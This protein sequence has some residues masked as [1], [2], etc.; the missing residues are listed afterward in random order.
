VANVD[1]LMRKLA[2]AALEKTAFTPTETD[3][4]AAAAGPPGAALSAPEG[5]GLVS[6]LGSGLGLGAGYLLGKRFQPA[7]AQ[8][9]GS[10]FGGILSRYPQYVGMA[11]GSLLGARMARKALES[12][13]VDDISRQYAQ[14]RYGA[15]G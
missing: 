6:L 8:R 7:L 13:D 3:F 12:R 11:G 9:L 1:Q 10:R 14:Y 5:Q 4:W 15:P 2:A